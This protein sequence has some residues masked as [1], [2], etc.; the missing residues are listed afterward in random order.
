MAALAPL[1]FVWLELTGRCQL[2]CAHCYADSG[3][4]GTHGSMTTV[5]WIRVIDQASELGVRTVQFIGGEPTL[6]PALPTLIEHAVSRMLAVEVFSNLVH[7]TAELWAVFAQPGVSLAT[8]Y[9]SDDPGQH[10]SITGRPSYARTRANIAQARRRGIPV[11][12]GVIDLGQGQRVEQARAELVDL[13]VGEIGYDRVREV[14]R[15]GRGQASSAGQLCGR[16]GEGVAAIGPDGSVRPCV[17]TRWVSIGNVHD[18]GLAEITPALS[19]TRD[20]LIA[21]GMPVDPNGPECK[22]QQ[23]IPRGYECYPYNCEPFRPGPPRLREEAHQHFD[24]ERCHQ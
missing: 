1:S 24:D 23:C 22:P 16:C 3:P 21:Q 11:R 5:D 7:V 14:G 8:S 12:A 10:A 6:H 17:F 15:G 13:G 19:V 9:Y 4:G 2:A 18:Q 20:T